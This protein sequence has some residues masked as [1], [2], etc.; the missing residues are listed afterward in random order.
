MIVNYDLIYAVIGIKEHLS[1]GGIM[2]CTKFY[3]RLQ[4]NQL[5]ITNHNET[6]KNVNIVFLADDAF[7]L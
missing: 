4:N 6:D 2:E 3:W 5:N 7:P 1:G